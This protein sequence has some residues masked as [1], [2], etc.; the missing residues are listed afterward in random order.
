MRRFI[1]AKELINDKNRWCLWLIDAEP[2]EMRESKF[3]SQRVNACKNFRE[4]SVKTGDAYKNRNTPWLFRDNHQTN[5]SYLAIPATVSGRRTYYTCN[6][7]DKNT[8]VGNQIYICSDPDG[9]NFAI[10]ESSM[11]MAWQDAIGGRLKNDNRFS[12]TVAWN[13]LPLP[14]LTS[15]MRAKVIEAGKAVL[16]ARANHPG[17]SLADLYDPRCMPPDLRKAHEELDKI[18]DVAFGATKPC[19]N[20]DERLEI[21]FKSYI[22]MTKE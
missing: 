8:I 11:F 19:S 22:H 5:C 4:N 15:D 18:V 17:Q 3:I 20:N 16:Q 21:L 13:N 1:G 14:E 10:I 2:N 9:I 6:L 7:F 12:N